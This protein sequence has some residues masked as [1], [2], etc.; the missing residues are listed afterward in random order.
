[1]SDQPTISEADLRT[2]AG[3]LLNHSLGGIKPDEKVMIKGEPI[4]LPLMHVLSEGVVE[5]GGLPDLYIVSP[6]NNRGAA[7]GA[8]MARHGTDHQIEQVPRWLKDRYEAMDKYVEVLGTEHPELLRDLPQERAQAIAKATLPMMETRLAKAWV[9][10]LYPTVE[11]ASNE[12]LALDRYVDLLVG[13]STADHGQMGQMMEGVRAAMHDAST[14]RIVTEHPDGRPLTLTMNI[15]DSQIVLCDGKRNFPD[16]EVFTSPDANSVQGEIFVDLPIVNAGKKIRGIHLKL[17]GG[18]IVHYSAEEGGDQL[19][20]IIETDE[21]SHRLGEVAFGMNAGLDEVLTH[22]L[23][24]E[25]VA[26][27]LHIAI[28]S[29]YKE[30]YGEPGSDTL[31]AAEASGACNSAAVHVDIVAD[32]RPGGCVREVWLGDTRLELGDDLLWVAGK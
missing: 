20:S 3:H 4:A 19:R 25:K 30:C 12:G 11:D 17:E 14:V 10:T 15:A 2:W 16:G 8:D 1:M 13:A 28:G 21:G 32:A 18:R 24:V 23:Y 31:T 29:S 27:T 26:G 5:A 22:P 6:D 9:I 7:W